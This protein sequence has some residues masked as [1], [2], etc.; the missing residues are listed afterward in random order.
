MRS[1]PRR[2]A[3]AGLVLPAM[4][5]VALS[6]CHRAGHDVVSADHGWVRLAA[7]P[8][9][10]SAA[11][12]NLHG[13]AEPAVLVAVESPVARAG[14]LHRMSSRAAPG[15]GAAVMSMDRIDAIDLPAR[16]RIALAPG[17]THVMLFGVSPAIKPGDALPLRLRLARGAPLTITAR[18]VAAGDPAPY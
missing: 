8:D 3:I 11:Y 1:K 10:P 12:F 5:S 7:L 13:G 15:G 14:E 2:A 16:A 6:G 4:M 17:G 18:V 9:R